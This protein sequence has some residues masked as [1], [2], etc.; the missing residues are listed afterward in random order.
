M[1]PNTSK[2]ENSEVRK[3]EPVIEKKEKTAKRSQS[4]P[5]VGEPPQIQS[6]LEDY[7]DNYAFQTRTGMI[8]DKPDKQ[9][10]DI[11]FITPNFASIKNNWFFGV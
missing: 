11:Y 9:N 4:Q 6:N 2:R 1:T 10:Q 7:V 5:P 8:P 3:A